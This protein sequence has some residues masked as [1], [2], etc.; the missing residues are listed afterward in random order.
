MTGL[1]AADGRGGGGREEED[2][3]REC[4]LREAM[5]GTGE[6]GLVVVVVVVGEAGSL[7]LD[8]ALSVATF[9]GGNGMLVE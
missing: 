4:R 2:G 7:P 1:V 8:L 5:P 9:Q 6:C 3:F